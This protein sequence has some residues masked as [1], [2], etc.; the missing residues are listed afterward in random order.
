MKKYTAPMM[1]LEL[2]MIE[3]VITTSGNDLQE[4][5]TEPDRG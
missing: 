2:F 4:G 5:E 1:E 3:D